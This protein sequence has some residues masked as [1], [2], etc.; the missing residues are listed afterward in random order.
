MTTGDQKE[1]TPKGLTL[2][3]LRIRGNNRCPGR[4]ELPAT[5]A[6]DSMEA[7]ADWAQYVVMDVVK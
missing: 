2:V 1:E 7:R 4:T 6:E 5:P 3:D